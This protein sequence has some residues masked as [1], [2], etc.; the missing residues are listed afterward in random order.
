MSCLTRDRRTV[1]TRGCGGRTPGG[2]S[3]G[4]L[5]AA[6]HKLQSLEQ[7]IQA[8][9]TRHGSVDAMDKDLLASRDSGTESNCSFTSSQGTPLDVVTR[10]NLEKAD[11]LCQL[12]RLKEAISL[13]THCCSSDRG[14]FT[15]ERLKH[16]VDA[17]SQSVTRKC[18]SGSPSGPVADPWSCSTCFGVLVEPI[19]LPCGHCYCRKCLERDLGEHLRCR[20]C[21]QKVNHNQLSVLRV[22][23]LVNRLVHRYWDTDLRAVELKNRGNALFQES[24]FE[25]ALKLYS[26]AV[27]LGTNDHILFGNRSHL[28]FKTGEYVK[29]LADAEEAVALKGEWPKG[30]YRKAIALQKLNRQD[31]AFES[32]YKCL[33]LE[34]GKSKPVRNELT[35][36][37]FQ[38]MSRYKDTTEQAQSEGQDHHKDHKLRRVSQSEPS[39]LHNLGQD[40]H[41]MLSVA[42]GDNLSMNGEESK[43]TFYQCSNSSDASALSLT[44]SHPLYQLL[45]ST[46]NSI[47]PL[48]ALGLDA[49][50]KDRAIEPTAVDVNDYEC[51]LCFRLLFEP[52]TTP[53]GHTFCRMCLD[54][55][56][57]HNSACPMCKGNLSQYL[58]ERR[59]SVDEFVDESIKRLLSQEYKER[60]QIHD[61]EMEELAGGAL[62]VTQ[63][64]PVFVCTV[65]FP[66]IPC[67][68]HVFEPRYRL[69]I[70]RCMETG[71]REFGMCCRINNTDPFAEYGTLLEIRDIQY[72][73]DGRAVVDT[74]GGRRFKVISRE[75]RDG[76]HTA[77]VEFIKDDKVLPECNEVLKTHHQEVLNLALNWFN[78]MEKEI[79]DG[80]VSHYGQ[81]PDTEIDFWTLSNGPA[82]MW[83]ILIILPLNPE[84]QLQILSM[85]SLSKR[86]DA[87]QKIIRYLT[88]QSGH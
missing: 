67:P 10:L 6:K 79:R 12:G 49:R 63:E 16:L 85:T 5:R 73:P 40:D 72:F 23:V 65:S 35:K 74:V 8:C 13:Y 37:L 69:M 58:A 29:A 45:D 82:W 71:T 68:L 25:E 36:V 41:R 50:Q 83:W 22:N 9:L 3:A 54:R 33:I 31:E 51:S 76:Y 81:I 53:C 44:S 77:K 20:K 18:G 11:C 19:S 32:F 70:R 46:I 4:Q 1:V 62:G 38:L 84:T 26:E 7:R 28:Y 56:L 60:E 78:C 2:G 61:R 17:L 24:R 52:V 34:E 30:H 15:P 43:G 87:I 64:V 21:G 47:K 39:Q 55:S 66:S 14:E 27:K 48:Q 86:L 80:I 88:R 57:D 42:E 75:V 59:E